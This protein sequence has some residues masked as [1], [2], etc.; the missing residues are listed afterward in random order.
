METPLPFTG[1]PLDRASDRRADPAWL[2][3][4]RARADARFLAFWQLKPRLAED[5]LGFEPWRGEF[6]GAPC[7]F[8]G[9]DGD[10]PLFAVALAGAD[11]PPGHDE[12]RAAALR[13]PAAQSAIAGQARALLDWHAR[14]DF[15]PNC[16]ARTL[17]ADGGARRAC[18]G[19]G[20]EHFP[21]TDP[22]AI[23]LPIFRRQGFEEECLVGRNARFPGSGLYSA[24]AGFI[25]PGET[26]EE[27]VR[28][29]LAEEAGLAVGRVTYHA[30]QFWPFPASL[31]LGCF[32]QARSRDFRIDGREIAEA[33][34]LSKTEVRAGLA[35]GDDVFRLP[36]P[37][38]IAHHLLKHWCETG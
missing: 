30:S 35:G 4:T 31:M 12:M 19:C 2:A 25:E 38:A 17:A 13:L 29:E 32:A 22:V 37:I 34:W 5:R 18:P 7:V 6:E 11:E 24:F 23:M 20:A 9:L 14:H 10:T 15:C 1:N 27:A 3:E 33:R 28:R 36:A 21:R 16:G 8:L 26:L